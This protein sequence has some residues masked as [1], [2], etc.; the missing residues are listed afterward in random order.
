MAKEYRYLIDGEWRTSSERIEAINPYNGEIAGTTFGADDGDIDDA[1]C[2]S[3]RAFEETRA[4]PAYRRAEILE[5]VVNGIGERAEEIAHT[6]TAESGKPIADARGEVKR[7]ACTFQLALEE[8]K[9][10]GGEV[11]PL[12]I[13]AGS[14]KRTG[15]VRRFPIGPILAITPFN[16]PLNLVAHKVAP[17]MASGNT[18]LLKPSP[19]TPLTALILGE[20]ITKAGW[21][22]GGINIFLCSN[23][24]AEGLVRDERVAMITFTGSASVGWR[25]KEMA[26]RKRVA[27]E[28][29]G[30]AGVIVHNDADMEYAVKRCVTGA[31]AFSG[32][33]CI[34]VQRIYVQ[35][36][37]YATFVERFLEA[38]GGIRMGDPMD[39]QMVMG[40]LIDEAA[41]VRTEE[42]VSEAVEGGAKL[43]AGGARSGS[44][45]EPTVLV[46]VK[47]EMRLSCEEAFAPIVVVEPYDAFEDAVDSINDSPYG[48]QTGLFTSD[49]KRIFHAFD[50]LDVGGVVA[51]DVPTYRVDNMPYG[52][53]KMSGFGREGVR[54]AMEEMTEPK[55][56]VLNLL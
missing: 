49:M 34:S 6:I 7:A 20:I 5:G 2:A 23:S 31:F 43:L 54:Y 24:Q 25:L 40:P 26:G 35:K 14:E 47:P 12:D 36:E 56:L 52:G 50:K 4:L 21:P 46:D 29:G 19:R 37:L 11:V 45:F 51:N 15:I 48:L 8:A 41:A 28:L 30:N 3:V 9:R 13:M 44:F 1:V 33:V 17:A 27:L 39:E 22:S 32:Q 10:L 18:I 53:V 55:L 42:W 16:F 38:V